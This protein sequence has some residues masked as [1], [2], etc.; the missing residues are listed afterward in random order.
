VSNIIARLD[1]KDVYDDYCSNVVSDD[2]GVV[3]VDGE[4]A[5]LQ[6][7]QQKETS[8]LKNHSLFTSLIGTHR[9]SRIKFQHGACLRIFRFRHIDISQ[10]PQ[11]PHRYVVESA[12]MS[13]QYYY[14]DDDDPPVSSDM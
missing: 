14:D 9:S 10:C 2:G 12:A 7:Q 1:C 5:K 4:L 13:Q 11:L 6:Y 3:V 8:A